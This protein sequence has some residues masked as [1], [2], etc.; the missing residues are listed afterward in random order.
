MIKKDAVDICHDKDRS[1]YHVPGVRIV[2]QVILTGVGSSVNRSMSELRYC[3]KQHPE[4]DQGS[5][6][7]C[8]NGQRGSWL[9]FC[10]VD[11]D[12]PAEHDDKSL[13]GEK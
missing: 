11:G 8:F 1:A 3:L 4:I 12:Q 9:S 6:V 5:M 2:Y 7:F 10:F 13:W